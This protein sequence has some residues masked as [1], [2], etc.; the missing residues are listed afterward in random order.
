M[1]ST[2]PDTAQEFL[3]WN[4]SDIE[5]YYKNLEAQQITEVNVKVWLSDWSRLMRLLDETFNRLYVATTVD[6]T[7]KEAEERYNKFLDEIYPPS[8][9]AD[10]VLK[11][12][13][14]KSGFEPLG[15]EMPMLIMRSEAQIFRKQNIP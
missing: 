1:C 2:L 10:Q 13:L 14:L 4:W 7:D 3:G 12:C 6:T 15:F 9:E 8:Q 11:E 5:P